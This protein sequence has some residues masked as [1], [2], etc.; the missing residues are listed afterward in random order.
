MLDEQVPVQ[1]QHLHRLRTVDHYV[2]LLVVDP[3]APLQQH[4][5]ELPEILDV[6]ADRI[7][8]MLR[9]HLLRPAHLF[10]HLQEVIPGLH[11]P[12]QIRI[13]QFG[14]QVLPIHHHHRMQIL[15]HPE[16]VALVRPGGE[17]RF[18][19]PL[20]P[21][22]VSVPGAQFLQVLERHILGLPL[23]ESADPG[24]LDLR[25]VRSPAAAHERRGQPVEQTGPVH[26]L[27]V[28]RPARVLRLEPLLGDHVVVVVGA[29]KAP[30]GQ[31]LSLF[32]A[33]ESHQHRRDEEE[34][35]HHQ[36]RLAQRQTIEKRIETGKAIFGRFARHGLSLLLNPRELKRRQE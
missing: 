26:Q 17:A 10:G 5:P 25:G 3:S 19:D 34:Q 21:A 30:V 15:R 33:A 35:Q 23:E 29:G 6:Q 7:A 31:P 28:D 12:G 1:S 18:H 20:G 11:D 8:W 27:D 24:D 32:L 16:H 13:S 36:L 4:L 22:R 2:A 14:E 9:V